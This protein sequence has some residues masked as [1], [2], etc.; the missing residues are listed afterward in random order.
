MRLQLQV[1]LRSVVLLATCCCMLS[2]CDLNSVIWASKAKMRDF[3]AKLLDKYSEVCRPA[4]TDKKQPPPNCVALTTDVLVVPLNPS[5]TMQVWQPAVFAHEERVCRSRQIHALLGH[6]QV[7][8]AV[9]LTSPA[10]TQTC[11][12]P[13]SRSVVAF[14]KVSQAPKAVPL[15]SLFWDLLS[16]QMWKEAAILK[17]VLSRGAVLLASTLWITLSWHHALERIGQSCQPLMTR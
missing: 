16:M 12:S 7:L 5:T 10:G 11:L 9:H 15:P 2:C 13:R 17:S 4:E 3:Q 6:A 8:R 1:H 14:T